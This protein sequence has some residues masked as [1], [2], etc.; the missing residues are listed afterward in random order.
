MVT[1]MIHTASLIHDDIIDGADM[2][3]SKPT[4]NKLWGEKKVL[5]LKILIFGLRCCTI[6]YSV[7]SFLCAGG[8]SAVPGFLKVPS[9]MHGV[10]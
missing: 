9:A 10:W 3:R 2:R 8:S 6:T 1:E 4:V 7:D 5:Q